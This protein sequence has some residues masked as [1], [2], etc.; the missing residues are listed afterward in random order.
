[1]QKSDTLRA[2]TCEKSEQNPN[3]SESSIDV[4]ENLTPTPFGACVRDM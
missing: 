2:E 1:M 3:K 4:C